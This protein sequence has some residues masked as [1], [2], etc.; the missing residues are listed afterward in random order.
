MLFLSRGRT[1][2]FHEFFRETPHT[3]LN[4]YIGSNFT[5]RIQ[6]NTPEYYLEIEILDGKPVAII[7][8]EQSSGSI[9]KGK[10][11][12]RI[13]KKILSAKDGFAEIVELSQEKVKIDLGSD[14]DAIIKPEDF[15]E[16]FSQEEAKSVITPEE[17]EIQNRSQL[18]A[19]IRI[20]EALYAALKDIGTLIRITL[21][22]ENEYIVEDASLVNLVNRVVD[23][24]KPDRIAFINC[25]LSSGESINV[26]CDSNG[27]AIMTSSGEVPGRDKIAKERGK[28]K[29]YIAPKII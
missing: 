24:V 27:C 18:P 29:V 9:I 1:L 21:R 6:I 14:P 7:A 10:G 12:L 8:Q 11:A 2:R 20:N 13:L 16:V 28:C 4:R 17:A 23:S 25:R 3:V 19:E 26:L 15:K 5:G 22:S